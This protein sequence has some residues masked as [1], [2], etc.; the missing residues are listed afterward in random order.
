MGWQSRR[1][2]MYFDE[3][4]NHEEQVLFRTRAIGMQ[5]PSSSSE[6][7]ERSMSS[8]VHNVPEFCSFINTTSQTK[9]LLT[10]PSPEEWQ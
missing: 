3:G 2:H 1:I 9:H 7:P 6:E 8:H 10:N 4:L 5:E